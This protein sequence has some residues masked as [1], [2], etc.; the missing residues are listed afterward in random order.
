MNHIDNYKNKIM[1]DSIEGQDVDTYMSASGELLQ[2][3]G[4]YY[5]MPQML[6]STVL[7]TFKKQ[8]AQRSSYPERST[9]IFDWNT[10]TDYVDPLSACLQFDLEA[11]F[12]GA[13]TNGNTRLSF[14][15]GCISD[16]I[17][18]IRILSKNGTELDRVQECGLLARIRKEYQLT[19]EGVTALSMAGSDMDLPIVAHVHNGT[20]TVPLSLLSG[21]FRP[22]IDGMKIPAGIASGLRIEIT[23]TSAATG[24]YHYAGP[25]TGLTYTI[26]NP[27]MLLMC[28]SLNDPT[29]G[30]L[31]QN[32]AQTG[33]E[34]TFVSSFATNVVS[35]QSSI[36]EQVKKAVS[37]CT[38]VYARAR[39][40]AAIEDATEDSYLSVTGANALITQ[41]QFR[42][43]SSY[44]PQQASTDDHETYFIAQNTF[45]KNSKL[46]SGN[47]NTTNYNGYI[48][49]GKQ[50]IGHN[51]ETD[52]RLNLSGLPL[53]NSN[54]LEWR[55]TF[56]TAVDRTYTIFI[57]F[58]AV[59]RVFVNRTVLKI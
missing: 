31:M 53:N 50:I 39:P 26:E 16:L 30:V 41:T 27:T 6:S 21:F 36:N 54:V 11:T 7:R 42:V 58:I 5:K 24:L 9:I 59:A 3:N 2:S 23:L 57:E 13:D 40:T 10:G 25:G 35:A 48:N 37:Q 8:Y 33:L 12:G 17:S 28:S 18:E 20:Y 4:L 29:Q 19:T 22:V 1:T 51:L 45:D 56:N 14:G 49:T 55:N 44:F 38:R 46:F 34:Y 43:G 32:S 47:M 52:D 15:G